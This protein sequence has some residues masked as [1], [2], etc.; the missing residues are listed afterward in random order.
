MHSQI[1][2]IHLVGCLGTG[3]QSQTGSHAAVRA[4]SAWGTVDAVRG[5]RGIL[6]GKL[7]PDQSTAEQ[8]RGD[9]T[10]PTTEA[11]RGCGSAPYIN[12]VVTGLA[13]AEA[14]ATIARLRRDR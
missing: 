14:I 7:D 10:L 3:N 5:S 1:S 12:M 11:A 2:F 4:I 9:F 13:L 6:F 8:I